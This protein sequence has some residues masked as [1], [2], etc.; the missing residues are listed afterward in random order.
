MEAE[1]TSV[2][3]AVQNVTKV[4]VIEVRKRVSIEQT[5]GL[6]EKIKCK[7]AKRYNAYT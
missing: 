2:Q 3:F 7:F 4:P 6:V 5:I 1:L